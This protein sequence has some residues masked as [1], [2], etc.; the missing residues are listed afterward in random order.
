ML[1]KDRSASTLLTAKR[2]CNLPGAWRGPSR[3][4]FL[5]LPRHTFRTPYNGCESPVEILNGKEELGAEKV[6]TR[7]SR[8]GV[9]P[10][11]ALAAGGYMVLAGVASYL[12]PDVCLLRFI[13]YWVLGVVGGGLVTI[14]IPMWLAGVS[15]AMSAYNK[16]S[17]VTSGVFGLVRHPIYSAW[18]VFNLPGIGLLCRSWPLLGAALVAY[19]VFKLTIRREDEYLE[20]RFGQAYLDYRS[21][22]SELL[23]LPLNRWCRIPLLRL[24]VTLGASVRRWA[25]GPPRR[26][27]SPTISARQ[28]CSPRSGG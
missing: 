4:Q 6:K 25:P 7:L 18:I 26:R 3:R 14:G 16:D 5:P 27:S 13:P 2:G 24:A 10:R 17:L 8:W 28:P 23:P 19:A 15:A 1:T 12:W 9:G 21:R 11:I 20:R 22:V